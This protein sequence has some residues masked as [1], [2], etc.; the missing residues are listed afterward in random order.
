MS[1]DNNWRNSGNITADNNNFNTSNTKG[2]PKGSNNGK[3]NN[4]M[5]Q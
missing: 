3:N 1:K 4:I 5:Q 2:A